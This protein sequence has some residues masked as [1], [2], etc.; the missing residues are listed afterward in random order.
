MNISEFAKKQE[1]NDKLLE[2]K[3]IEIQHLLLENQTL[4]NELNDVKIQLEVK[5]HSL[6]DK[7]I[8]NEN[9]TDKLKKTYECQID[10]LNMMIS[11]LTA[12]LKEKTSELDAMRNDKERLQQALQDSNTGSYYTFLFI[13]KTILL[14]QHL[15]RTL[16]I[17]KR[18]EAIE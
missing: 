8:D 17:I 16:M 11:K 12:Y 9:L 10:N 6:K 1:K 5:V 3:T 14:C 4:R 2:T 7:L 15:L 18:I 13:Q